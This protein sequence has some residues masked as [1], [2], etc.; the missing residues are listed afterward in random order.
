MKKIIE[1]LNETRKLI[2]QHDLRSRVERLEKKMELR[3]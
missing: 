2:G 1:E 3:R